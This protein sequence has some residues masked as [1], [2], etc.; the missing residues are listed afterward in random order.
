MTAIPPRTDEQRAEA[1]QKALQTR[2]ERARL[3]AALRDGSVTAV[4]VIRGASGNP[5][6]ASVRVSWL[7]ESVPGIGP[8]RAERLMTSLAIASSRRVQGLGERQRAGL[9]AALG[10][11]P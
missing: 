5:V 10:G 3:R 7:L 1:L 6:W 4:D 11:S 9:V 8:V 2:R